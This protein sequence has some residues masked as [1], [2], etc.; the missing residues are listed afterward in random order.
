MVDA[1]DAGG[2]SYSGMVDV[3]LGRWRVGASYLDSLNG[4]AKWVHAL[5]REGKGIYVLRPADET[6]YL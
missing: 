3:F 5:H 1:L 4:N 6:I 2:A